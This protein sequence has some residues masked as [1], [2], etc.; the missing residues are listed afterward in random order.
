[1]ADESLDAIA[2]TDA[3]LDAIAGERR[4]VSSDSDE[5]AL[6]GL[7]EGWRDDVRRRPADQVIT[8]QQAVVALNRGKTE[9]GPSLRPRRGLSVVA[10]AAAAVL[11]IGGFGAVVA[12]SGPGDALYG[13]HT[14]LFGEA[15]EVRD[16]QVALVAK[17][18]MQQVQQLIDQGD[19][20]QA[21]EKLQAVSSQVQSVEDVP[22]KTDLIRQ[23]NDLSVKVGT[24]QPTQT[25]PP[26]VPGL[27]MP[28]VPPGVTLLPLPPVPALEAVG[29]EMLK[30]QQLIEQRDWQQAQDLLRPLSS[31][32]EGVGDLTNK[33][34]LVRLFNEMT[35]Q[36][37]TQDAAATLPPPPPPGEPAPAL[38][39][40][41]SLLPLPPVATTTT[42]A[43]ETTGTSTT[44]GTETPAPTSTETTAAT[45][46][47]SGTPPAGTT[48]P[49]PPTS[50][51]P[52]PTSSAVT[53][54][55]ATPPAT[56]NPAVTVTT[57]APAATSQA[58]V[59]TT[60]TTSAP[61]VRATSEVVET[62]APPAR[63]TQAPTT[64]APTTQA[65]EIERT[66]APVTTQA[67]QVQEPVS[68]P[69]VPDT[70]VQRQVPTVPPVTTTLLIPDSGD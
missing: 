57:T 60:V 55:P 22:T 8:E 62:T 66:S 47:T 70:P 39:P 26:M 48:S 32:V 6:F 4:F 16:D 58:P 25:V 45:T 20:Q 68:T 31:E 2:R 53:T 35:Y 18:E 19:W 14:M 65:P 15:P 63:S 64:Q 13:L 67:P 42:Q 10:S 69:E 34:D 52:T 27:P 59:A 17:T 30:V 3:L 12:G 29:T 49:A 37:G 41:V 36:V 21:E 51:A 1:M 11:C 33:T 38:P 24:Q 54:P 9:P 61:A 23:W 56:S 40:G 43:P 28:A 50:V 7:L 5:T 44:T 46:P